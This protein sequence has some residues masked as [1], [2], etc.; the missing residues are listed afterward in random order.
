MENQKSIAHTYLFSL[1]NYVGLF[2]T[3]VMSGYEY[4]NVFDSIKTIAIPI[5][6]FFFIYATSLLY[7]YL[8]SNKLI[9]SEKYAYYILSVIMAFVSMIVFWIVWYWKLRDPQS[10]VTSHEII[11]KI[12]EPIL[13][14]LG[15]VLSEL[16]PLDTGMGK[17]NE[18]R[19]SVKSK[20]S[21][22][23]NTLKTNSRIFRNYVFIP[24]LVLL[25][26]VFCLLHP[27]I[28][29]VTEIICDVIAVIVLLVSLVILIKYFFFK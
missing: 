17:L 9:K 1:L 8:S 24:I 22:I 16:L 29:F 26:I 28:Y 10:S 12:M 4:E 27:T 3:V 11:N 7:D 14:P 2:I 23:I 25:L 13:F 5:I 18:E 6:Q 19:E 15:I 20:V 21:D